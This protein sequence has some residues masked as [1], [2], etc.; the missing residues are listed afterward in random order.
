MKKIS[1]I[2]IITLILCLLV[3]CG[4]SSK[5]SSDNY[6]MPPSEEYVY[7][8]YKEETGTDS[9]DLTLNVDPNRKLIFTYYLS[10][11]T[12]E[13]EKSIEKLNELVN[14][15]K[16]I[17]SD[18][19]EYTYESRYI[20]LIV[21]IPKDDVSNFVKEIS[22]IESLGM[23][24]RRL[25]SVDVTDQYT[26][27]ELRL[28][29][30]NEKLERLKELQEIQ[31]DLESL[32]LLESEISDTIFRIERIEGE[33][34]SLDSKINYTDVHISISE[35]TTY[36]QTSVRESFG[37]R[38]SKAFSNSFIDFQYFME[39]FI[40][41]IIYLLPY[42]IILIIVIL[43]IKKILKKR[44]EKGKGFK[45]FK[46]FRRRKKDKNKEKEKEEE[47]IIADKE[48]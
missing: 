11:K 46:G 32:I 12:T 35:K 7:D 41:T 33:L 37:S 24:D 13:Y 8:I 9:T 45:G 25:E 26:D 15:Y 4:G 17:Y 16:G 29:T 1:K 28:N 40:I 6:M 19:S 47:I 44:K 38:I 20:D 5:D 27:S 10:F 34:R 36:V 42:I 23:S 14:K 48:E 30:L 18:M 21:Q 3:S 43:I 31:S 2:L 39:D 22:E